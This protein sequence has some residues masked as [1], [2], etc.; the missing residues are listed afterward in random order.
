MKNALPRDWGGAKGKA[1]SMNIDAVI[2]KIKKA[3]RLANKTTEDGERETAMRMAKAL[4]EKHGLAFDEIE[5]EGEEVGKAGKMEE[6]EWI[7][8][9]SVVDGNICGIMRSC[10]GVV[11]MMTTRRSSRKRRFTY[12]GPAINIDIAKYAADILRREARRA[13]RETKRK[14]DEAGCAGMVNRAGFINGFFLAV[15]W[16]LQRNP[17]RND[18]TEA[19]VK[20]DQAFARYEEETGKV[21]DIK[22]RNT[23]GRRDDLSMGLGARCASNVSLC[24]PMGNA[25][26]SADGMIGG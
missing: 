12:F 7:S 21:G 11:C 8:I 6:K 16:K 26:Q 14:F 17:L 18:I 4:A 23:K 3:V 24:R 25:A 10:L 9:D 22:E 13:W 19:A 1:K 2:E 15:Y 20:A 5:F